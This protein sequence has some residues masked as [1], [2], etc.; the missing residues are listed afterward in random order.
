MFK[1]GNAR[2]YGICRLRKGTSVRQR[3]GISDWGL[4]LKSVGH[5]PHLSLVSTSLLSW[6]WQSDFAQKKCITQGCNNEE[7]KGLKQ[8]MFIIGVVEKIALEP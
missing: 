2:I 7:Q 6:V 4:L 8:F 1:E 3:R 5:G